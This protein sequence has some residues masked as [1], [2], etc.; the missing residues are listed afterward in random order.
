MQEEKFWVVWNPDHGL[1]KFKH[2]DADAAE[3]E[4]SRLAAANPGHTFVVLEARCAMR[5]TTIQ[6]I[7][8]IDPLPF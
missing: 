6:R 1:P 3:R 8:F 2:I 7:D 4:A 5:S